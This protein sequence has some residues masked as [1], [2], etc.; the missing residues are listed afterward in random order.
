MSHGVLELSTLSLH[1][2][3]HTN[4]KKFTSAYTYR[5]HYSKG[6]TKFYIIFL[7]Y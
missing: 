5:L 4:V 7:Q 6:G 1:S 3:W 2:S